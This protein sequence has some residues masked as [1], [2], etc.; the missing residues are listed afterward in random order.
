MHNNDNIKL[1]VI[2][3]ADNNGT[4]KTNYQIA[5]NRAQETANYL[6]SNFNID[7]KRFVIQSNGD[8]NNIIKN[9]SNKQEIKTKFIDE[10]NRR[11][12]FKIFD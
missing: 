8:K 5:L 12:D 2:G 3:N 11:V 10:I 9:S 7:I 1:I 4:S 6:S